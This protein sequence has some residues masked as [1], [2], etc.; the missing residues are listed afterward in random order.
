MAPRLTGTELDLI[1]AWS[2]KDKLTPAQIHHKVAAL[3]ARRSMASPDLTSVRRA[4]R[5]ESFRSGLVETRGRKRLL[6]LRKVRALNATRKQLIKKAKGEYEVR[7]ADVI[8]KTRGVKCHRSTAIRGFAHAGLGVRWR[9]AREKLQR[10]PEMVKERLDICSKWQKF[11]AS[12]WMEKVDMIIDNKQWAIPTSEQARRHLRQQ[13]VRGHLRT[14]AEGLQP[15][16]TKPSPRKHRIN[17]GGSVNLCAGVSGDQVVFWEYLSGPWG[18][19]AAAALYQGPI[20]K[21]LQKNRGVKRRYTIMQDNDPRGYK[22]RKA[23]E[24]RRELNIDTM[25]LPR[26]SPD[27]NPLDYGIWEAVQTRMD[28][29]KV[30]GRESVKAF[31]ARLK[32]EQGQTRTETETDRQTGRQ[33]DRQKQRNRQTDRQTDR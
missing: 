16:F 21:C 11:P 8:K 14:P 28:K 5:G 3:R 26:Y 10:S 32:T 17:P 1:K 27:L 33:T 6:T 19:D 13:R 2:G 9:R 29:R 12:H 31:K 25:D 18:G 22:S 24:A 7:W 15:E 30:Q 4:L 20:L 23:V